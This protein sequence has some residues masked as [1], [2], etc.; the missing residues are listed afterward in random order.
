MVNRTLTSSFVKASVIEQKKED[1]DGDDNMDSCENGDITSNTSQNLN[2]IIDVFN[3]D[4][5]SDFEDFVDHNIEGMC[6][7]QTITSDCFHPSN[8]NGSIKLLCW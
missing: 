5:I 2:D 6:N 4:S 7:G 3:Y 1:S 8:I